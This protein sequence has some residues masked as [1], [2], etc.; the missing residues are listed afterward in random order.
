MQSIPDLLPE[1]PEGAAVIADAM[2]EAYGE[3][4]KV[5]RDVPVEPDPSGALANSTECRAKD[6][7]HC[8]THGTPREPETNPQHDRYGITDP[9]RLAAEP[10]RNYTRAKSA[11]AEMLRNRGGY[12]DK[13]AFRPETGWIRFD[14]GDAGNPKADYKGG[15]GISHIAAKHPDDLSFL[16]VV[17]ARGEAYRH[18][19]DSTKTYFVQEGRFAVVASL[20]KGAKKTITEYAPDKPKQ[21]EEIKKYPRAAKPGENKGG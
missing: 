7:A 3:G 2:A 11:L 19:T 6:P 4:L 5:G 18:P 12:V 1:D 17:I 21:L 14:W 15:H 10:E 13:A 8:P 20:H 16:P 9:L